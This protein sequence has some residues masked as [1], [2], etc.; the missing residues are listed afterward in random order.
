MDDF[1]ITSGAPS[2]GFTR[3]FYAV[4]ADD[5]SNL[6]NEVETLQG[7]VSTLEELVSTLPQRI[8]DLEA[9]ADS[10][11]GDINAGQTM[12]L[13]TTIVFGILIT[14]LIVFDIFFGYNIYK[15]TAKT[16]K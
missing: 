15:K 5:V 4:L 6:K 11:E 7:K 16:I 14:L 3:P 10:S 12:Q 2:S 1:Q 9:R 13:I 8:V